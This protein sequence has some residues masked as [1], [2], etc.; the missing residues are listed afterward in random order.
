MLWRQTEWLWIFLIKW[1]ANEYKTK[2]CNFLSLGDQD[3]SSF[4]LICIR[5]LKWKL[6]MLNCIILKWLCFCMFLLLFLSY[7]F[8]GKNVKKISIC[9]K[10]NPAYLRVKTFFLISDHCVLQTSTSCHCWVMLL[11]PKGAGQSNVCC[12]VFSALLCRGIG[13][14][15][16]K[17]IKENQQISNL[18]K[19]YFGS[20]DAEKHEI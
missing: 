15:V 5:F 19:Y 18:I 9:F 13:A 20:C 1:I 10:K 6:V 12:A 11:E 3:K 2:T 17:R 14:G 4:T 8:H 7:L 16:H